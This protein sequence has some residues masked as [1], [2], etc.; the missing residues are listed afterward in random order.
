[1]MGVP[2]RQK[3]PGTAAEVQNHL[4]VEVGYTDAL[5]AIYILQVLLLECFVALFQNPLLEE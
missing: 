5:N 3:I 2:N 1:M 4:T